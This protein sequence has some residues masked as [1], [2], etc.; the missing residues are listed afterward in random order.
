MVRI[1]LMVFN[2]FNGSVSIISKFNITG[3][4][5]CFLNDEDSDSALSVLNA[6]ENR[7]SI[8]NINI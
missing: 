2:I 8:K 1:F 7:P 6:F 4:Y 5:D 3:K